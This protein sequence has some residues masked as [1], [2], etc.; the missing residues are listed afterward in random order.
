[1]NE[2]QEILKEAG[3]HWK[4]QEVLS[5]EWPE[6][7]TKPRTVL[8]TTEQSS[9]WQS[10]TRRQGTVGTEFL[11]GEIVRLAGRTGRKAPINEALVRIAGEMAAKRE[12][13]GKYSPAE[14]QRMLGIN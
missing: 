5:Q 10:L 14:L 8:P 13:P 9:T 6:F 2:A 4:S 12:L 7:N 11:N 1:M 3:V